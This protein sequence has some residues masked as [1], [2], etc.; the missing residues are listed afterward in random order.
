MSRKRNANKNRKKRNWWV[1][2]PLIAILV[3][4]LAVGSYAAYIY[5][6]VKGNI[7]GQM[8]ESVSA[9]DSERT[10]KKL[11]ERDN[12]N[13]LL[14]GLDA[15]SSDSGRSDAIM[16][17]TLKPDGD[18]MQLISIP[19]DTRTTIIGREDRGEDKI[20]HAYAFGGADMAIETVENFLGI[21]LDFF[22]RLNMDGLA[23]LID[24]LGT[25]T[26]NNELEFSQSG[27]DFPIGPVDMDGAKTM[28]YVRMRKQD[29]AGDFGRTERQRKVIEAIVNEGATVANATRIV[30]FTDILGGNM[31]TNM[32]FNDM[33]TLLQHYR[34]TRRNFETYQVQGSGTMINGVYYYIVD[35]EEVASVKSMIES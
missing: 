20:N 10:Q 17:M 16:V 11:N 35:E 6:S 9:I 30:E 3:L 14:L 21:D 28:S 32:E 7:D 4:F 31:G 8:H 34:N 33:L 18:R 2:T 5:F 26:V 1:L 23:E 22:V 13:I 25:I 24:E 12:L 15:E 19:R 29:P 27:Y